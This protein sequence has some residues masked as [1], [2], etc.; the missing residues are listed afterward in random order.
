MSS[1]YNY[2]LYAVPAVWMVGIGTHCS[3]IFLSARSK[4]IPPFDN[5]APRAFQAKML[6]LSKTSKDAAKFSRLEAAQQNIYENLGLFAAAVVAGNVARLPTKYL[7]FFAGSYVLSRIVYVALYANNTT[8]K[9]AALRSI[10]FVTSIGLIFA[11]F[12]KSA[13][14]LN[15]LI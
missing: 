4:E 8:R 2:S 7:N 14:A 3:A 9:L 11:T 1:T 6:E 13:R 12:S 5:N 15:R 10:S